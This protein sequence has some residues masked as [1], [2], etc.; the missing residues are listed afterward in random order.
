MSSLA[1]LYRLFADAN[2]G[3]DGRSS[4]RSERRQEDTTARVERTPDPELVQLRA[5]DAGA[6]ERLFRRHY[7]PLCRFAQMITA[8]VGDD[9]DVVEDVFAWLWESR[10]RL[11]VRGSAESYLYSAVRHRAL[12]A[13]RNRRRQVDLRARF[14]GELEPSGVDSNE[15]SDDLLTRVRAV[16][17]MLPER[18]RLV[19]TLR[20][21]SGLSNAQIA[22]VLGI[23][24]QS[25]A[26]LVQRALADVRAAFQGELR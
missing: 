12:N 22:E 3:D 6:F 18:R 23:A 16:I 17:A 26:N 19:L 7:L 24:P 14:S 8:S 20:W 11:E 10:E 13:L 2:F 15:G 5:G 1:A 25:V 9:S 4:E 21:E